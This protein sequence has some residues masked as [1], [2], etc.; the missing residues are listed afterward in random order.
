MRT[1]CFIFLVA[2]FSLVSVSCMN[3]ESFTTSPNKM[4]VYSADTVSIDT[5]FSNIPSSTRSFWVYNRS[6]EGIKLANAKLAGGNQNGFRAN[7]DGV[8]LG[9]TAGYQ[10]N[11]LE[12]RSGDS[13]RVYVE[14]TAP[15]TNQD[16]PQLCQDEL[17]FKLESG[18]EQKVHL[19]AWTWN[20][21]KMNNLVVSEDTQLASSTPII[22]YGKV[23]ISRGA[24]LRIAGGTSLYFHDGAG[25][26]VKG[27]L[28]CEGNKDSE[29][30]MRGDRLDR[31]FD[32]LP[33][34]RVSGQ[35][36]GLRFYS[37]STN[38]RLQYVELHGAHIG[39][40][41]DE[42]SELTISNSTIHNCKGYGVTAQSAHLKIY[43]S[44]LSNSLNDCLFANGGRVEV[45]GC[46]IAQFYPF[47]SARG[48]ALNISNSSGALELFTC[49]NSLITGYAKDVIGGSNNKASTFNYQFSSCLLRTVE[50]TSENVNRFLN[51]QYENVDDTIAAGK[52]NFMKVDERNLVYD[53]RLSSASLANDKGDK[54]KSSYTDRT[55][56]PR[57]E[58]PD[59]GAYERQSTKD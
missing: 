25:I 2:V 50:P 47:D 8:Y 14:F 17:V 43:D 39:V 3:D 40:Q 38:N 45:Q 51:V 28:V 1:F 11:D 57:L 41:C 36:G 44:Q 35:W 4:L 33:Y 5:V 46:T 37:E 6:G 42:N 21:L 58:H 9:K 23:T 48:Y 52:K 15:T 18:V 29:V 26:D 10:V 54:S 16:K 27:T 53:F 12:V 22:I 19:K 7:I 55:G 13:L 20:A 32:Y 34:D 56:I 59:I 49:D 30:L 31:V 24:T